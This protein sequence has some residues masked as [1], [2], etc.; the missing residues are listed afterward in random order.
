[1]DAL[2]PVV[3]VVITYK[4]FFSVV[5]A[6]ISVHALV[7]YLRSPFRK[8][9][10]GPKGLPLL[11][12]ILQITQNQWSTFTNLRKKFG[13]APFNSIFFLRR[14]RPPRKP[15]DIIYLNV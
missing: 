9:H 3:D 2:H 7:T 4:S 12:N 6:G 1:M 5:V 13:I 11:G 10:P 8:L 15:G 14:L